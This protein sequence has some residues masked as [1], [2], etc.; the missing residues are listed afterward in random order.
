MT[1]INPYRE[2]V[3]SITP[4]EFEEYC[5]EVLKGYSLGRFF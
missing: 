3:A 2:F 4:I 1:T 5:M